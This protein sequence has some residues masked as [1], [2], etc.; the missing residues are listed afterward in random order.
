MFV[1]C[2]EGW[3]DMRCSDVNILTM[4]VCTCGDEVHPM[5][6]Q[7]HAQGLARMV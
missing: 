1:E 4:D 3:V 5:E 7:R 2:R 6:L